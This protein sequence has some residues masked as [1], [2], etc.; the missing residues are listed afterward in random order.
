MCLLRTMFV[1]QFHKIGPILPSVHHQSLSSR[2]LCP[3]CL[4]R[5]PSRVIKNKRVSKSP[6]RAAQNI[7]DPFGSI[8]FTLAPLSIS[9]LAIPN[10]RGLRRAAT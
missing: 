1:K 3:C 7:A 6:S 8:A 9:S 2:L 5:R 10:G 4:R